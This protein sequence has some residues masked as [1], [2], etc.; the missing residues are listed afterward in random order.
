MQG[1]QCSRKSCFIGP[2]RPSPMSARAP[3]HLGSRSPHGAL[4]LPIC[5]ASRQG[6]CTHR[7]RAPGRSIFG[8]APHPILR[9]RK[10]PVDG[11]CDR[12]NPPTSGEASG[13]HR[14]DPNFHTRP[15]SPRHRVPLDRRRGQAELSHIAHSLASSLDF[16]QASAGVNGNL[17][18]R[19]LPQL[20]SKSRGARC[21]PVSGAR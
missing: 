15:A 10:R 21:R 8:R 4:R 17:G 18:S 19:R 1:L 11:Q 5:S 3:L 6:R 13:K 20:I 14:R 7:L 16:T 2:L 12:P 9:R